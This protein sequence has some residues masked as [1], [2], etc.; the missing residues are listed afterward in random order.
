MGGPVLDRTLAPSVCSWAS[1]RGR[2]HV[3]RGRPGGH[4]PRLVGHLQPGA[5]RVRVSGG[6]RDR[7]PAPTVRQPAA[8]CLA[9]CSS[10]RLSG[11]GGLRGVD[12]VV[13]RRPRP[14]LAPCRAVR[15]PGQS[16][17]P[18]G[19]HRALARAARLLFRPADH[20]PDRSGRGGVVAVRARPSRDSGG[21]V[22]CGHLPEA[23]GS[24][25]SS[26]CAHVQRAHS[27][28][29]RLGRWMRRPGRRDR[30]HTWTFGI[31]RVGDSA[32]RGA[33]LASGY[34]I[35]PDSSAGHRSC[36]IHAVGP[37]RRGGIGDRLGAQGQARDRVRG[38]PSG[39]R[40][41][42]VI[43][44]RGGL[45]HLAPGRVARPSDRAAC[46][47]SSVPARRGDPYAADDAWGG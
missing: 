12:G 21:G 5:V 23:S 8:P 7:R 29:G 43:F 28:R 11:A 33:G 42:R 13:T 38:G 15:R 1:A 40:G 37:S 34:R 4:S 35:H 19:R 14:R 44:P 24:A 27:G 9:V 18:A 31:E 17:A 25:A 45:Q 20:V 36:D 22:G 39:N 41:D 3:L 16:R 46:L 32:Q 2:A 30:H 26:S 10:H 47:A 6:G